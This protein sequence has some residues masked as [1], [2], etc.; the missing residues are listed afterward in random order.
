MNE[1]QLKFSLMFQ[2]T[3]EIFL[4]VSENYGNFPKSYHTSGPHCGKIP[5]GYIL[6]DIDW[7]VHFQYEAFMIN[8]LF[9]KYLWKTKKLI[10]YLPCN[11]C[12]IVESRHKFNIPSDECYIVLLCLR[13][14]FNK[15]FKPSYVDVLVKSIENAGPNIHNLLEIASELLYP[16]HG[17]VIAKEIMSKNWEKVNNII[18]EKNQL[19]TKSSNRL[20]EYVILTHYFTDNYRNVNESKEIESYLTKEGFQIVEKLKLKPIKSVEKFR[21]FYNLRNPSQIRS[22]RRKDHPLN[23]YILLDKSPK[24]DKRDTADGTRFVNVHSFDTKKKIR[25]NIKNVTVHMSDT[26]QEAVHNLSVLGLKNVYTLLDPK[27]QIPKLI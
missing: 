23:L 2:K 26:M 10:T 21:Y 14:I 22:D 7:R 20:N 13:C 17:R 16:Q 25:H 8:D 9:N 24:F 27:V 3:I 12:H 5:N 11:D 19:I 4:N 1:S 18:K 6:L 15:G